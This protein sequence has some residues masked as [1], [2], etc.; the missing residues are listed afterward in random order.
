MA[1]ATDTAKL[2]SLTYAEVNRDVLATLGKPGRAYLALLVFCFILVGIGG[3][4]W[5][6]LVLKGIGVTNLNNPVGWGALITTFVFWVGI[7]HAGTLISA[8]LFLLR[9][10]WRTAIFRAAETSTIF[11]VV[12]AGLFPLIHLGR[13]WVFYYILPY[14]N[15][16]ELWPNFRSPLV[17]DVLAITTYLTVSAVFFYVGLVPDI[18]AVRDRTK[19]GLVR[20]IWTLCSLGWTGSTRQWRHYLGAYVLFAGLATPLVISVHSVVSWDFAM[21]VVPGWHTTIFAP[22]FVAGAILSGLAMVIVIVIPL[23][24]VFRIEHIIRPYH[25][26]AMAKMLLF[27]ALIVGYAYGIEFFIAWYVGNPF[28]LAVF[29]YRPTG[30]YAFVFWGMVICNVV[31]PMLFFSRRVRTSLTGLFLVS[32]AVNCGMWFERFNII[33]TSLARDFMP[34]AW[35]TY[36]PSLVEWGIVAGSFGWFFLLF[37]SFIKILPSISVAEVKESMPHPRRG[38]PGPT[39]E[40]AA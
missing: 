30:D 7:G 13:L 10:P 28:E 5:A 22:Y 23:R 11:A 26:E 38:Q 25:L 40:G 24:R 15:G 31:I 14:P 9:V 32:L 29:K 37:L 33:V 34:H 20:T 2:G 17:W 18:A 21:S 4:C 19:P 1:H 35:G 12:T 3:A 39:T 6:Y 27:T 8:I 36:W 16:R